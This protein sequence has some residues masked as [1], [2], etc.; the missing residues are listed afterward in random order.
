IATPTGLR[1]T[2]QGCCTRLPWGERAAMIRHN[3]N[4]VASHSPG[5]LYSAT[6]GKTR[7]NHSSQPQRGCVPQPRVAVL[8][9]PGEDAV[10]SF[11]TTPT[12]LRPTAQGCC[13]QLPWGT[14]AMIHCNP[15][16]V[17][18]HSPGLLYSATLGGTR[19]DDSSQPQ[20]GCVP[21]PRVA[22][23]SY[24]GEDAVQSFVTTPTGLRHN[25]QHC[26]RG[27]N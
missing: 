26:N 21:Q 6:L 11:V 10:Q 9:Y 4:G 19:G 18:S 25:E 12:G 14:L 17:A 13:T 8:S 27:E 24:P 7:C 15:N 16:G 22:V 1:P 3:P 20:R 5:L 23:L 2:A